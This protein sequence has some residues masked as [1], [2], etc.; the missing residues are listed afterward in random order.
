[1]SDPLLESIYDIV[2]PRSEGRCYRVGEKTLK[3]ATPSFTAKNLPTVIGNDGLTWDLGCYYLVYLTV[4]QLADPASIQKYAVHLSEFYD[5]CRREEIDPLFETAS[6]RKKPIFRFR[7]Q[8]LASVRDGEITGKTANNKISNVVRFYRWL[9]EDHNHD[10]KYRP[11]SNESL[12]I[13]YTRASGSI[14]HKLV[15]SHDARIT[16]YA[17]SQLPSESVIVD[18]GRLR[19][20]PPLEQEALLNILASNK[21]T[22]MVLIIIFAL[23]TGARIQSVLTLRHKHFRVET[24]PN[25]SVPLAIGHGTSVDSKHSKKQVLII[26]SFVQ[27]KLAI[28]SYS[29]RSRKRFDKYCELR[30][31]VSSDESMGDCYLFL[32]NQ[33]HPFYD[34]KSDLFNLDQSQKRTNLRAGDAVRKF[35]KRELLP[36]MK[37]LFGEHYH[38]KF[39]D[40]RAT[41]GMNLVDACSMLVNKG[42]MASSEVLPFVQTRM[43]HSNSKMT[44]NYIHYRERNKQAE[45][46]IEAYQESLLD[47]IGFVLDKSQDKHAFNNESAN[48]NASGA[49]GV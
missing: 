14:G 29:N 43:N 19:P 3:S 36:P 35:I 9:I 21:N 48:K 26:P 30:D 49:V 28:Y 25:S 11:F 38:F 41:Y 40:L 20:L 27:H 32:S 33:G 22:E 45:E 44:E 18:D 4:H 31:I 15:Q 37:K 12:F 5:F 1:M 10:F 23:T 34:A 42:E 17:K 46:I 16:T 39:H 7:D 6:K 2:D 24:D 47:R 8:L 13:S